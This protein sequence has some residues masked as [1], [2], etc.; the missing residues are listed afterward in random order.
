M[1]TDVHRPGG[2][3]IEKD[4]KVGQG[5]S[6]AINNLKRLYKTKKKDIA[7]RLKEFRQAGRKGSEEDIFAEL[8]FCLLTPQSK[9]LNCWDA[10]CVAR[11]KG[12]LRSGCE[13]SI[14]EILRGKVRFHNHKAS[15]IVAA[16]KLFSENGRL[17]IKEKLQNIIQPLKALNTLRFLSE[18]SGKKSCRELL[19]R[20]VKGMGY[21]EASHFLRNIGSGKD[22]AILDRHILKNLK[23]LRVIREIPDTLTEKKYFEIEGRMRDFSKRTGIL[24]E[25]L[26]LLFW[27]TQTGHIFK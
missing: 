12:L 22:I 23:A 15:Y 1:R 17:K 7:A 6:L 8:C 25:V 11:K 10:V 19:V 2:S 27:S 26:D 16:R 24:L 14:A 18:L 3:C 5:F 4:K 20:N 21:K 13:S 9:A